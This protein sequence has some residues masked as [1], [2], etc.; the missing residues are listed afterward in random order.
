M[1]IFLEASREGSRPIRWTLTPGRPCTVGRADDAEFRVAAEPSLSRKHFVV[2]LLDGRLRVDRLPG[3]ANPLFLQGEAK[4]A[5][6]L[7]PG[8]QFVVGTTRFAFRVDGVVAEPPPES[9]KTLQAAELYRAPGF[10]RLRLLDL[11]ELPELLRTKSETEFFLHVAT[12]LRLAAQARWVRIAAEDGRVLGEEAAEELGGRREWSRTLVQK[13]LADAPRPTLFQWAA[14]GAQA[15]IQEGTDWAIAAAARV[16]GEPAIVFYAA[17]EARGQAAAVFEESA[18]LVGLVADLVGRT[19]SVRRLESRES[20]LEQFFSK[21][22]I[23]K[24]LE[25]AGE[26][27]SLEP[28]VAES[29]V[30]FFDIRGFSKSTE[31]KAG[32]LLEHIGDL[33]RVMT[34]MTEEIFRENGVV[35]QYTGDGILACWNVPLPDERHVDRAA[36]AALAMARRFAE[37]APQW[38]CGIG[39]HAGDVVAGAIGSEQLFAY[40]V[41]GAVVNQASRIEGIT[42]FVEAPILVSREVALRVSPAVAAPLRLGRFQPAGMSV[43]LELFELAPPPGDMDRAFAIG[44]GLE[45]LEAGKWEKAYEVLNERPAKDLPARFLKSLAEQHRRRPPKDWKGIIELSEK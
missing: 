32:S 35:L 25:S 40:S 23:A 8:E 19:L 2:K 20:R 31:E 29:T 5:F 18:R 10:D 45:A 38:K 6:T 11:L 44:Q 12:L 3:T 28:R 36:R 43:A 34:A 21:P 30:M 42:K 15:T 37:V 13:A 39:L 14:G 7:S 24:I 27:S 33:R 4:D 9:Q 17:G 1:S 41:L 16:P 26:P 22:V